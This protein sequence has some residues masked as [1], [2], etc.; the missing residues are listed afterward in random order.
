[1]DGEFSS[2]KERLSILMKT[3]SWQ[4][5]AEAGNLAPFDTMKVWTHLKNYPVIYTLYIYIYDT[6]DKYVSASGLPAVSLINKDN[7]VLKCI[8]N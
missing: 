6:R 7:W 5:S 3:D 1:M 2:I 4:K 8:Y